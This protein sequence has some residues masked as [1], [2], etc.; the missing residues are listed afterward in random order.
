VRKLTKVLSA[1][2]NEKEG[3][4][5]V[6]IEDTK[7]SLKTKE[8][9]TKVLICVGRKANTQKLGLENIG[10]KTEKNGKIIISKDKTSLLQ[11]NLKHI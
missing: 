11:T 10:V 9:F 2:A 7:T 3:N 8:H 1:H 5:V 6:E 4:V